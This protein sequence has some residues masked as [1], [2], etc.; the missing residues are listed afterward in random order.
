MIRL[1]DHRRRR[2][3]AKAHARQADLT[4]RYVTRTVPVMKGARWTR[5]Q[6]RSA[7]GL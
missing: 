6:V 5:K 2:H 3:T 1:S 7:I 4:E